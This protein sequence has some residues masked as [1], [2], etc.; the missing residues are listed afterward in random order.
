MTEQILRIMK[1]L[2]NVTRDLHMKYTLLSLFTVLLFVGATPAKA[3]TPDIASIMAR[4]QE[5]ISEMQTLQSEFADLS[6][7]L[8][9]DTPSS[10]P[11]V[12][13]AG[14]VLGAATTA[15]QEEAVYGNTNET[16]TKIQTLLATDPLIYADGT[17]SGY[18]GPKTQDA[19]RNLQA[20]FGLDPVGVVGPATAQILMEYF[21]AYPGG[22]YP[23]DTLKSRVTASA[24]SEPVA[25]TP[26]ATEPVFDTGR[27]DR[28]S[29]R[30]DDDE[31]YLTVY[32][33]DGSK[34]LVIASDDDEDTLV[35]A[36]LKRTDLTQ[37]EATAAV[38]ELDTNESSSRSSDEEDDAEDAIEEAEE[39]ID[40]ADEEI[41]E[42]KD[43]D[44]ETDY[45]ED[46][47]DEAE[48]LLD[49]A[50]DAYDDEDY[51]EAVELAEEAVEM[52]EE[53]EDAI[54]D[55]RSDAIDDIV[56][57]VSGESAEVTVEY[58]NGDD[59]EFT[60]DETDEDDIIEAV[61]D[62]L[63]IS[64]GDVEDEIKFERAEIDEIEVEVTT[65]VSFITIRYEDG[66]KETL[67][68]FEDE[69]DE[70]IEK[71]AEKLDMDEDDIEDVIEFD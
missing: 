49:D 68:V 6:T 62:R 50:E 21:V 65:D 14:S 67:T 7:A 43:D 4:M 20:R 19:I 59:E 54:G 15:L 51:D 35:E 10:A 47:L 61:A 23:Q 5:I 27:V 69:E 9:G 33:T 28:L 8:A 44:E 13:P 46:L 25:T 37:S 58:D 42:A 2:L 57:A 38:A 60:V 16:I 17:V 11:A 40:E 18:F 56:A 1:V 70:L 3:Q 55:E 48:D 63:D 53:A 29:M 64:K 34:K 52:A 12:A 30:E 24:T 31:Y 36:L 22:S 32:F 26:T 71:L 39:A 45:A 66:S 41:D